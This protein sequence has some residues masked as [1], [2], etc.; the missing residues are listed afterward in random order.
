MKFVRLIGISALVFFLLNGCDFISASPKKNEDN[1]L[2]TSQSLEE[3]TS[4]KETTI[5]EN[6]PQKIDPEHQ[7][8]L[9]QSLALAGSG[10]VIGSDFA[11]GINTLKDVKKKYGEPNAKSK[12]FPY[13]IYSKRNLD[14][15]V[16]KKDLIY[17]VR[18]HDPKL[19]EI[20]RSEVVKILG[21]PNEIKHN[22]GESIYIYHVNGYQFKLIYFL[23][24]DDPTI[25]HSSVYS[26]EAYKKQTEDNKKKDEKKKNES[27]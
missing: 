2:E 3:T 12:D 18:S 23:N 11:A 13:Y 14:F 21:E 7:K 8:Y 5:P 6:I 24:K 25:H 26:E 20:T 19:M 17:D 4:T 1:T 15:G 22:T 10:K 27:K 16:G 9:L